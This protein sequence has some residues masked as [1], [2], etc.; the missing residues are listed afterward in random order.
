MNAKRLKQQVDAEFENIEAILS[1]LKKVLRPENA[2]YSTAEL[3]AIATYLH[4]IYNGVENILKRGIL[5]LGGKIRNSPT[6]H[7]DLL[8][9]A[10]GAGLIDEALRSKLMEYLSFRHYFVHSYVF[11]IE[12]EELHPLVDGVLQVVKDVRQAIN[13]FLF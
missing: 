10:I 1:E 8:E 9:D 12:W 3:A 4:N 7:K 6:W 5:F 11:S 2:N 13:K